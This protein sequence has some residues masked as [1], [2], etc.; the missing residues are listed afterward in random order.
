[1]K[2]LLNEEGEE[3]IKDNDK[4]KNDEKIKDEI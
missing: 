4:T 3:I 1:M 2:E